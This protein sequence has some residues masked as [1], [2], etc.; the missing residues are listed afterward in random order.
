[1]S[2][3]V[4]Y[5]HENKHKEKQRRYTEHTD[6]TIL[7]LGVPFFSLAPYPYAHFCCIGSEK[8]REREKN[9]FAFSMKS[10]RPRLLFPSLSLHMEDLSSFFFSFLLLFSTQ[11]H[12][13]SVSKTRCSAC[14]PHQFLMKSGQGLLIILAFTGVKW[15]PT[16]AT[17]LFLSTAKQGMHLFFLK[18]KH[19]I[20]NYSK[21]L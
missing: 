7:T 16:Q 11:V 21:L 8:H 13:L 1:M 3:L 17:F 5:P 2:F 14:T 12:T 18:I 4:A 19:D 10:P 6:L 20:F 9:S 15:A